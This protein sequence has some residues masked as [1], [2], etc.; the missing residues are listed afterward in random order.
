M[1]QLQTRNIASLSS[2]PETHQMLQ[3]TCR[4][5]AEAELKPNAAKFDKDHIY[6]KE[7][8]RNYSNYAINI[9]VELFESIGI[10][11]RWHWDGQK[12]IYKQI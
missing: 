6:P 11:Y 7:Q 8:V 3:K 5:F 12:S 9:T 4:D 10:G 2:L 1:G